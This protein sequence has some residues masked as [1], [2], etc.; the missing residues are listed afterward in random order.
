MREE[1]TSLGVMRISVGLAELVM[2]PMVSGPIDR[3]VLRPTKSLFH[4][5]T[6]VCVCEFSPIP[7][8]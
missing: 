3:G 7:F 5:G 1:E 2:N 8:K 4:N 6:D